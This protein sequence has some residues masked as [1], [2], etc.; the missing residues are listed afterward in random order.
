MDD[1]EIEYCRLLSEEFFGVTPSETKPLKA[2]G[3]G[4][5]YYRIG[6]DSKTYIIC[7]SANICENETFVRLSRY[8][9]RAGISV[10]GVLYVA[11]GGGA[12]ILGDLGD[13]DLLSLIS[14]ETFPRSQLWI[15]IE[16]TISRLVCLQRLTHDEWKRLVGF[17]PLDSSLIRHDF[18][19]AEEN[20][21]ALSGI[22]YDS[23]K[24][25]CQLSGLEERLLA[26]PSEL[27]G[28]MFRDFQSR[29]IMI[30]ESNPYFIDY[31]SSRYGPGIY[32]LVSFAWQAKAGFS[33]ADRE[34]II[35]LY[36][37][38]YTRHIGTGAEALR[39]EVPYWA[40][41]RIIQTLGA[42]GLRGLKEG[43]PHFISSIPP[44]LT[45]LRDIISTNGLT[46]SYSELYAITDRLLCNFT[47]P[48]LQ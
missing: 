18:R 33:R 11:S 9:K 20:L 25:H 2:S 41:F 8:L 28:L 46:E 27:W 26:Y 35:N 40:M 10:P 37:K 19:Y 5:H 47:R 34:R 30:R 38:E 44:A 45:N 39:G 42:Y 32:D 43:K 14:D 16:K 48:S 17:E 7:I 4:R 6:I 13:T 3:S 21:F 1:K 29:N 12:Y 22:D 36:I 23:H 15:I 24:L 31:Q